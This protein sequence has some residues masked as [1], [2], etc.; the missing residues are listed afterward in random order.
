[1]LVLL[2]EVAHL[3]LNPNLECPDEVF[4]VIDEGKNQLKYISQFAPYEADAGG[5]A[6]ADFRT[7]N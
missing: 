3:L 6:S 4:S 7:Q 5:I 1:L 2:L